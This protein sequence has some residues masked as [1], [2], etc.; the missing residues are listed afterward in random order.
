MNAPQAGF[1]HSG[2]IDRPG[3][4][5]AAAILREHRADIAGRLAALVADWPKYAE[6]HATDPAGFAEVETGVLVDYMAGLIEGGDANYR[7][8][9]V[10]EKAKQ[11]HG[12]A[13]VVE[14]KEAREAA[15]IASERAIFRDAVSGIAE[16][17]PLVDEAFAAVARA[18]TSPAA[19]ELQILFVGD[20]LFQDVLAFLIGPALDDGIRIVATFAVS[21]DAAEVRARLAS[22]A[23][24]RFD[25]IFYSPFTYAFLADYEALARPRALAN[26]LRVARHVRDAV[27]AGEAV[28]DT[29]ADLFDC[30]IVTHLPAPIL[31]HDGGVRERIEGLAT[32]PARAIAASRLGRSLR[33]RAARRRAAGQVVLTVDEKALAAT[34]G[35]N[36]AGR[37]LYRSTLQHPARFGALVADTYRDTLF[38]AAHLLKRKLVACDLDNT[39]WQGVIGEGLGVTQYYDR[40]APLLALKARGVVLAI[41][42]KNDP[43]KAVWEAPKG[44]LALDDFV[45][46]QINWDPKPLNMTRIAQHL[47]LKEKD[48]V[49]VDDR[50][51]ERA[52]VAERFPAMVVLDALDARSWR[53]FGL[54]AGLLPDKPG[55]DR[56]DFYRQRDERQA[57]IAAESE[58]S[59]ESR[60]ELYSELGLKLVIREAAEADLARATDLINRTNQFNMAG[61]RVTRKRIDELAADPE[62]KVL[63]ADAADRFGTMGTI[64]VLL[65][66]RIGGRLTIPT[67]VLS[68]RVFGYGMEYAILQQARRVAR[69]GEALFGAFEETLHNEPCRDV[70]RTAGFRRVEGGWQLAA[71]LDTPI[72]VPAWL[73]VETP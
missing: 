59:A 51:D 58:A 6:A 5:A 17:V 36:E 46:R 62:A 73:A 63:I 67:F 68:C 20:C 50:A 52:M 57:F 14:G 37:F 72:D 64:A 54:W 44:R 8:L 4:A 45:S 10:G 12:P 25:L 47:N 1:R 48:F 60:A 30:P 70:Y 13:I 18:F 23:D 40:Q 16:A 55:A 9:Y 42:S 22:L 49:F 35:N 34:I 21:H 24:Q 2:P 26:P 15:L 38:V 65:V 27:G 39:L 29:L 71:A 41:N 61:T 28:F 31:R 7:H 33:A 43:A 11:F 3:R 53:L 32:L 19:I 66:E 69:P 56:T